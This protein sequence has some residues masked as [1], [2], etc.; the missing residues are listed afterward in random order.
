MALA[1]GWVGYCGYDTVRYVY[2]SKIPFSSAPPDDRNLP[3]MHLALYNKVVVFDSSS[4]LVYLVVWVDLD[5]STPPACLAMGVG[6]S[7]LYRWVGRAL[8]R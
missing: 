6:A 1:G 2:S 4:K 8:P 3:E 7:R 5:V